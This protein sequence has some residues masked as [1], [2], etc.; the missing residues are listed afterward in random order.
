M[1]PMCPSNNLIQEFSSGY[2]TTPGSPDDMFIK[3]L[4]P[5]LT[6]YYATAKSK[7]CL[8]I[9]F[10]SLESLTVSILLQNSQQLLLYLTGLIVKGY[11]Q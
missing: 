8:N 3:D 6:P 11:I 1:T 4:N 9:G 2:H 10:Q 5:C 7:V